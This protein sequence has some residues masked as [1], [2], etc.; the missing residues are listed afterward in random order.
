MSL[1]VRGGLSLCSLPRGVRYFA[2]FIASNA[3]NVNV[4]YP[5]RSKKKLESFVVCRGPIHA[6][7]LYFSTADHAK[8][9]SLF[10]SA[11]EQ[12][13]LKN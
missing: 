5:P 11:L 7:K 9:K 10:W 6:E 8:L 13:K 3:K 2:A 4:F 1:H 12:E